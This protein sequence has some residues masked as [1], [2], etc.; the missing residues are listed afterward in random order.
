MNRVSWGYKPYS[1][2]MDFTLCKQAEPTDKYGTP[3]EITNA[4]LY[5]ND[6]LEVPRFDGLIHNSIQLLQ[7]IQGGMSDELIKAFPI[8]KPKNKEVGTE[9]QIANKV[10]RALDWLRATEKRKWDNRPLNSPRQMLDYCL[11]G[12]TVNRSTPLHYDEDPERN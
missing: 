9:L 10:H 12:F 11:K 3:H 8:I 6:R 2:D 1:K 4:I 7:I 5:Y